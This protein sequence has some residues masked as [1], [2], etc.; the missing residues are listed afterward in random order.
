MTN[1]HEVIVGVFLVSR[2][3]LCAN[4]SKRYFYIYTMSYIF[5]LAIYVTTY[6][7]ILTFSKRPVV[8]YMYYIKYCN[9]TACYF[10]RT[11]QYVVLHCVIGLDKGVT[12]CTS[13]QCSIYSLLHLWTATWDT[14][15]SPRSHSL[16]GREM[17]GT[18]LL[19]NRAACIAC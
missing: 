6:V 15:L 2:T 17:S 4:C 12:L 11:D 3:F 8:T 5:R 14:G 13:S 16:L 7:S 18:F 10:I 19:S 9:R 1:L